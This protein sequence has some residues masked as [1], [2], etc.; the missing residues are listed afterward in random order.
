MPVVFVDHAGNPGTG[1]GFQVTI[2]CGPVG[3][4]AWRSRMMQPPH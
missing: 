2:K 1:S 3:A 4:V